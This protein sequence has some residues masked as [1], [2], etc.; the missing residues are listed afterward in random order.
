MVSVVFLWYCLS[1]MPHSWDLGCVQEGVELQWFGQK[2][3]L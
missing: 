2:S 3:G 1:E